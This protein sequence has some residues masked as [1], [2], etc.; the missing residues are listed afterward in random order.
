MR[1][2]DG[3]IWINPQTKKPM[4][5]IGFTC[6]ACHTG[7]LTYQQTTLLI[8]GG[9]ALTDLGMFRQALGISVLFT[10]LVPGRFERFAMNV[11]GENARRGGQGRAP[12]AARAGLGPVQRA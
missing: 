10:K 7:R 12:Q 4:T 1:M 6:A 11:L 2:P 3:A 8:D 5:G 9:P